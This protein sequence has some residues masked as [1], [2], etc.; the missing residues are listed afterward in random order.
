MGSVAKV[1]LQEGCSK[2]ETSTE[3]FVQILTGEFLNIKFSKY[4]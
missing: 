1:G 3:S 4:D 2:F